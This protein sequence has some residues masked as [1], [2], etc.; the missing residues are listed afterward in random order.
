MRFVFAFLAAVFFA[1]C[2]I[3]AP[4]AS[5]QPLPISTFTGYD[6]IRSV[7][8]SPSGRYIAIIRREASGDVLAVLDRQTRNLAPIQHTQGEAMQIDFVDFKSDSRIIFGYSYRVAVTQQRGSADRTRRLDDAFIRIS[9]VMASNVDGS[10]S[11]LLFDPREQNLPRYIS[12]G[13]IS[14]LPEDPDHVLLRAGR[15]QLWRVNVVTGEHTVVE[16][17]SSETISWYVDRN[18]T[19]VLRQDVT[20]GGRGFAWFRRGPGQT[21]WVQIARF[22]GASGANSGPTFQSA[23]PA[24][25][26]GQVFV[27]AR[28]DGED[29]SALY[30]Y[31][32]SDGS[33]VETIHSEPGFD[34]SSALID[35]DSNSI[36]AACWWG[37]QWTCEPKDPEFAR[38]WV[39]LVDALGANV[40]VRLMGRAGEGGSLWL[41]QTNGPQD[42]GTYYLYDISTRQLSRLATARQGVDA[43]LLPTEQV[44][45]YTASDGMALWG[46]LWLPPGVQSAA[47]LPL[48][49]VPHG[50]PEG[51]DVWGRDPF[52]MTFASRGYAVFQPNFRGGGGFGRAFVEAGHGQWGQRMQADVADGT[53]HLIETGVADPNRIC[54]AGWS[55]GGYVA[56]TAS[57]ENA[58]L[59]KCSMAGAGISDLVA[60]LRWV[61]IGDDGEVLS[62]GGSG[63]QGIAYRYWVDAIGDPDTDREMLERYSAARNI[64]RIRVPLLIIHGDEDQ[65]VPFEQSVIMERGLRRAG[66]PV[67]L[68]RLEDTDHYFTPDQ[69]AAWGTV[70]NESLSFFEQHIGPGVAPP[71]P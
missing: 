46:Y 49:V 66:H 11:I 47:N 51:R 28:R 42:L 2:T 26:P 29:T 61:R 68:V 62:G 67:R 41:V 59:F 20:A 65:T 31:D 9:H 39:G 44:V 40:N 7:E 50:G 16:E 36:L 43:S 12:P 38:Y 19:P 27:L 53:R 1:A 8:L 30:L 71:S 13:I 58:D 22:I 64:D 17:G 15:F 52:A 63:S 54:I 56:F 70:M 32:T 23:G 69:S 55:Y 33:Y 14:L 37:Y 57:F 4:N 48:I 5:A 34:V 3:A 25:E 21:E 10:S 24:L 60:M 45:E 18:G 6:N 35:R